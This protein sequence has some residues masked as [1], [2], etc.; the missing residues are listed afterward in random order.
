MP[1]MKY[2][3]SEDQL[4]KLYKPEEEEDWSGL[5]WPGGVKEMPKDH[6]PCGWQNEFCERNPLIPIIATICSFILLA[7][8]LIGMA[9]YVRRTRYV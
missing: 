8:M 2:L 1:L 3:A 4:V 6:P 5:V 9:F 7:F